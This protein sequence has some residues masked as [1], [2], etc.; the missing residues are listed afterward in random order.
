ML[1]LL[2]IILVLSGCSTVAQFSETLKDQRKR[3]IPYEGADASKI[4]VKGVINNRIRNLRFCQKDNYGRANTSKSSAISI[5]PNEATYISFTML[6][7]SS[8]KCNLS[9]I[10]IFPP[11]GEYQLTAK[12]KLDKKSTIK[13]LL[14]G[15][16][17]SCSIYL[18]E[19]G[20][21]FSQRALPL[22]NKNCDYIQAQEPGGNIKGAVNAEKWIRLNKLLK[23]NM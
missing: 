9:T 23:N 20:N 8:K 22:S 21:Y 14:S 6:V 7:G 11:S 10:A 13:M 12:S 4:L 19:D 1:R 2:L 5:K 3:F 17:G 16:S 18:S 15:L